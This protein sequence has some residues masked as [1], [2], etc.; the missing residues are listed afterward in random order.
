[1]SFRLGYYSEKKDKKVGLSSGTAAKKAGLTWGYGANIPVQKLTE[2]RIP[3]DVE[4]NF[5]TANLIDELNPQ[6]SHPPVFSD[7]QFLFA[8]G[9]NIKMM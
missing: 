2:N 4:V 5:I 6:I 9:I 8:V 7:D 1:M 3:F